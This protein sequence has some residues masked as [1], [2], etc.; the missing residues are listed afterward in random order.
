MLLLVH[1]TVML[2]AEFEANDKPPHLIL[3][4]CHHLWHNARQWFQA[5]ATAQTAS[6]WHESVQY[7]FAVQAAQ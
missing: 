3:R 1:R 2:A 7:A 4:K 5:R 6:I